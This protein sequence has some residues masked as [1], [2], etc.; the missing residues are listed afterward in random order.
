MHES[1]PALDQLAE[2]LRVNGVSTDPRPVASALL[3][4]ARVNEWTGHPERVIEWLEQLALDV[5][6]SGA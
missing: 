2:R 4:L 5:G 3:G 1:R 6:R